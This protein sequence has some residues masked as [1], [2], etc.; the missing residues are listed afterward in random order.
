MLVPRFRFE[1]RTL[2]VYVCVC[3][4]VRACVRVRKRARVDVCVCA[5]VCMCVCVCLHARVYVVCAS[6]QVCLCVAMGEGGGRSAARTSWALCADGC[7]HGGRRAWQHYGSDY[8]FALRILTWSHVSH[9]WSFLPE[10]SFDAYCPL[11]LH[12]PHPAGSKIIKMVVAA[13]GVVVWVDPA[14]PA[15]G[16]KYGPSAAER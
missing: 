8:V 7:K 12:A 2:V 4:R 14:A 9:T 6:T 3:V 15:K 13:V 11:A 5:Y 1:A 16:P 10:H